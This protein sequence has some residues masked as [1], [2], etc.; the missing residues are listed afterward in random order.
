MNE[1]KHDWFAVHT[2]H[3]HEGVVLSI[4]AL[5]GFHTFLPTYRDVRRWKD[6]KKVLA[7]PLFPG[8][9]FT[10]EARERRLDVLSTPGVCGVLSVEGVPAKIPDDEMEVVIRMTSCPE[11]LQPYPFIRQ[12]DHVRVKSGPLAGIEGILVG[13]KDKFRLVVSI[14]MMGR[15]ASVEIDRDLIDAVRSSAPPAIRSVQRLSA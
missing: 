1:L 11:S 10:T 14:Q 3:Q 4:L 2:R 6:R 15:S 13:E 12:G 5:K 9:V 8:Y 7:L